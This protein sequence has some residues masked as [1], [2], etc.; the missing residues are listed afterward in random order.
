[1]RG[2]IH[3]LDLADCVEFVEV[4][5]KQKGISTSPGWV[6]WRTLQITKEISK[7]FGS[8]KGSDGRHLR[9]FGYKILCG[10]PVKTSVSHARVRISWDFCTLCQ[11]FTEGLKPSVSSDITQWELSEKSESKMVKFKQFRCSCESQQQQ[12]EF[13]ILRRLKFLMTLPR[14][15]KIKTLVLNRLYNCKGWWFQEGNVTYVSLCPQ[16]CVCRNSPS[17]KCTA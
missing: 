5:K 12:P 1:M 7:V 10:D 16:L 3:T 8:S 2:I 4:E 15:G 14:Y 9:Y 11:G 13:R 6:R 17:E